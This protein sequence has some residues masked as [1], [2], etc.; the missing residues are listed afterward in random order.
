MRCSPSRP[1]VF[2]LQC[3]LDHSLDVHRLELGKGTRH[4]EQFN[5]FHALH[6]H[7]ECSL[8]RPL[9]VN[10]NLD[11]RA[12]ENRLDLGRT[13]LEDASALAVLDHGFACGGILG[14]GRFG[15]GSRGDL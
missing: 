3:S 5:D 8:A 15:R 6:S 4:I 13:G 12:L 14:S 1:P 7:Y 2:F 9:G 11:A 10:N